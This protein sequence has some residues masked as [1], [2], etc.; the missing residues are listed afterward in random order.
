MKKVLMISALV[1]M[2]VVSMVSGTLALYTTTVD[3]FSGSVVAKEFVLLSEGNVDFATDL[4]IAP[5]ETQEKI[6]TVKNF[7]GTATTE[8]KM[9]VNITLGFAGKS[10][11]H[12]IL[13]LTVE[14]YD[15]TTLLASADIGTLTNGIGTL[16]I[17]NV[18]LP[19]NTATTK[20]YTVKFTWPS[21]TTG[22]VDTDFAGSAFGTILTVSVVGVQVP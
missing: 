15:D 22:V 11:N 2:I 12:Q 3:P 5:S 13:P 21:A 1:M 18:S 17:N 10:I 9:S 14:V 6:F 8:V 19:A 7:S 4:G 16:T 20:T